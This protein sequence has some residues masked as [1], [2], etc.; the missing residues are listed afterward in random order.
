MSAAALQCLAGFRAKEKEQRRHYP[1][2]FDS[3]LWSKEQNETFINDSGDTEAWGNL[4][5]VVNCRSLTQE[6]VSG[7]G[8]TALTSR[9]TRPPTIYEECQ[10]F[11]LGEEDV[12]ACD[13]RTYMR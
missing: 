7:L 2:C 13:L 5:E 9:Q 3:L 1:D 10:M 4:A 8:I 12:A 11:R 6:A